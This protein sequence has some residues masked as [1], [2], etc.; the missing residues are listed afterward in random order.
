ML[1]L[2]KPQ[3]ALW[4][5]LA[6]AVLILSPLGPHTSVAA[7]EPIGQVNEAVLQQLGIPVPQGINPTDYSLQLAEY[8]QQNGLPR[9][10]DD[11]RVAPQS[12]LPK[13]LSDQAAYSAAVMTTLGGP[14]TQ[15]DEVTMLADLDGRED[16]TADHS[17]KVDDRSTV[18]TTVP[19]FV[20]WALTRVA[21]SAHTRANG[22]TEN[23]FYYGDSVGN[24]YVA[25]DGA[26]SDFSTPL[27]EAFTVLNVPTILN[28]FGTLNSDDQIVITGL[29]V[30][31]VAD[32]SS[33]ARVNGSYSPYD[34]QVGEILYVAFWDTGGGLRLATNNQLVR[35]GV[36]AFPIADV[37]SPAK[38][39]PAIQSE[40]GFP[41]TVGGAFGVAYSIY[42]NL[43]GVA[44]DDDGNV[45]FQQVDLLQFTGA[46]IVKLTSVDAPGATGNQD[47]SL[48]TNGIGTLTTL[49]PANGNY[50]NISGPA[51][52]ITRV[53][54]F[55]GTAAT[56][57]NIT[58]LAAGPGN[59][60]YA[61]MSRSFVTTDDVA[62]QATEGLFSNPGALGATPSMV[63]SFADNSGAFDLCSSQ[64]MTAT[65]TIPV[66]DNFADVALSGLTNTPGVN[67]FRVFVTGNGPD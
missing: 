25:M 44:V 22:F 8:V 42:G 28:A 35:S 18:T 66:P 57:G 10:A 14:N 34:G 43:A 17:V 20:D 63:V 67:N 52:Q 48:A 31:P 11:D 49:N 45:Y 9:S 27:A 24:V 15:F 3:A 26:D 61:S 47:R 55:S 38:A 1:P 5:V 32:L 6:L 16:L 60:L 2:R 36:L 53:T 19:A 4:H 23:I 40:S 30:N 54:N 64:T 33:F 50:S 41:V 13:N 29:G 7:Q 51:N 21:F 65:G 37:T 39:P 62:S 59:I 46:N 58:G 12:G 56:F